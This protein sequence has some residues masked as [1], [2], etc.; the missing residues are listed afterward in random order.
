MQ[1][2]RSITRFSTKADA[3]ARY[4]W[5][6]SPRA[7][8]CVVE[9]ACLSPASRVADIGSGTGIFTRHMAD[10]AGTVYAVEPNAGMREQAEVL[11]AGHRAFVSI[12][13]CAEDTTLPD[14]SVDVITVAQAL[15]WFEPDETRREFRRILR[16]GGW[17]A[18]LWNRSTHQQ[19][20]E[21]FSELFTEANGWDTKPATNPTPGQAIRHFLNDD[22]LQR[23]FSVVEQETWEHFLGALR[24]DSHAPD[25][26]HPRY[27]RFEQSARRVFDRFEKHGRLA[28]SFSTELRM[29]HLCEGN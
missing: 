24:S 21:A 7:I 27:E 16:P 6:Y 25:E 13:G 2:R 4:R 11:L 5:D 8:A 22:C 9:T 26:C 3:Y 17:L 28:V 18:V 14:E 23:S 12:N 19:L 10:T 15:H 29:G 20:N 1:A